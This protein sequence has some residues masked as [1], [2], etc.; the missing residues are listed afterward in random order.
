MNKSLRL[1][2]QVLT[3]VTCTQPGVPFTTSMGRIIETRAKITG[4]ATS[5][6]TCRRDLKDASKEGKIIILPSPP[7]KGR[8]DPFRSPSVL[9]WTAAGMT[10]CELE[11]Q[12]HLVHN[13]DEGPPAWLPKRNPS[14]RNMNPKAKSIIDTLQGLKDCTEKDHVAP[15]AEW[16][17]KHCHKFHREPMC[18]SSFFAWAAWLEWYGFIRRA[19]RKRR[20]D[21]GTVTNDTSLY[22]IAAKAW[23]WAKKSYDRLKKHFAATEVQDSR[24][25]NGSNVHSIGGETVSSDSSP[26]C[27]RIKRRPEAGARPKDYLRPLDSILSGILSAAG[28]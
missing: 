15:T 13:N 22:F 5:W 23:D 28:R 12:V 19:V 4:G 6:A 10:E 1:A 25:N 20:L 27:L 21:D 3:P 26:P 18:R 24:L 14:A 9:T 11:P 17:I 16:I 7:L 2:L 8:Y